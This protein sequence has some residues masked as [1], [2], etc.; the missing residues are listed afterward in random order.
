MSQTKEQQ[1]SANQ[2]LAAI[3]LARA[4]RAWWE[5]QEANDT[6]DTRSTS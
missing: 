5:T 1:P 3:R 2:S 4:D 6:N